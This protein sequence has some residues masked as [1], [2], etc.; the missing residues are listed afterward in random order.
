MIIGLHK[1]DLS[2]YFEK[3]YCYI[4]NGYFIFET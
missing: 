2:F 1:S 3:N 4:N